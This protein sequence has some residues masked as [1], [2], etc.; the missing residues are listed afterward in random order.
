MGQGIMAMLMVTVTVSVNSSAAKIQDP[1]SNSNKH[2]TSILINSTLLYSEG[3]G[4]TEEK[5]ADA[6]SETS[7]SPTVTPFEIPI[8]L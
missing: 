5:A 3:P 7:P 6:S 1:K 4:S 2:H 8:L